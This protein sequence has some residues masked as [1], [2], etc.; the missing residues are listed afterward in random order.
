MQHLAPVRLGVT[1]G[2]PGGIGPEITERAARGLLSEDPSASLLLIGPVGIAEAMAARL[3]ARVQA[4]TVAAFH[5]PVGRPSRESGVA[6]LASLERGIGLARERAIDALCT[7][8][9]SKQAVALTGSADRGHT[10][11]LARE[12]GAGAV[13]MAFFSD[14]LKVAL[15]TGHVSLR[16]AIERL[17][18]ELVLEKAQLLDAALRRDLGLSQPRLALAGLNPHAGEAGLLGQE[19]EAVLAPAV[20]LAAQSGLELSG[21]YPADSVFRR[22]M[23]GD[24]D[25]VVALYHDQGL[26]P[27]KL[28]GFGEA[29]NVTLGLSVPRTSPDHGTAYDLVGRG[30]ADPG[31]MLGALR[32]A[33]RLG[34]G[35]QR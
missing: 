25:G 2:D 16:E 17:T 22:A 9:I 19:E 8:P 35:R 30:L 6:S 11:I 10:E 18:P 27:V 7:A 14:A 5:G 4:A 23:Q 21:P 1:L 12:L 33:A 3:G 31:G 28:L 15:T 32:W 29:V 13:A 26:I 24:F 34:R 20:A